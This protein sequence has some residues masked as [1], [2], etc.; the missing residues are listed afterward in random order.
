MIT[1]LGDVT[2]GGRR[3]W[4][5]VGLGPTIEAARIAG[6][7][8]RFQQRSNGKEPQLK[9]GPHSNKSEESTNEDPTATNSV[10]LPINRVYKDIG[11]DGKG[12][13]TPSR[14][15]TCTICNPLLQT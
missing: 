8:Q 5:R 4:I 6:L 3:P 15:H 2:R 13:S 7:G 11:E 10:T 14:T 9:G 12:D 1:A